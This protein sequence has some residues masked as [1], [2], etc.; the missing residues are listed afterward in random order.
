[1]YAI[2]KS[3]KRKD[4]KILI[5]HTNKGLNEGLLNT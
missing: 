4:L 1:M 5:L 2:H 3:A